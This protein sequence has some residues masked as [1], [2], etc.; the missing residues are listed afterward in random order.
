MD[1]PEFGRKIKMSKN[2]IVDRDCGRIFSV[3]DCECWY[4][5]C[6]D[7]DHGCVRVRLI[8]NKY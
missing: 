1:K 6:V 5:D 7:C 3:G 8:V 4:A 2:T